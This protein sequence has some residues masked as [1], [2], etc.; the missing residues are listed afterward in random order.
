VSVKYRT[1]VNIMGVVPKVWY[2]KVQ[3]RGVYN[4]TLLYQ[5]MQTATVVNVQACKVTA[6]AET[7]KLDQHGGVRCDLCSHRR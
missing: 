1:I 2:K 5:N 7:G 3:L 4:E 6:M